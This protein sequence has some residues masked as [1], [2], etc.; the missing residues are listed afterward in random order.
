[1]S[2]TEKYTITISWPA[3]DT[4]TQRIT[5]NSKS[6]GNFDVLVYYTGCEYSFEIQT[7]SPNF[8]LLQK[9]KQCT[10]AQP[11][12]M[13]LAVANLEYRFFGLY[14]I[15]AGIPKDTVV[16]K[17]N[18]YKI[19]FQLA[20]PKCTSALD[21]DYPNALMKRCLKDYASHDVFFH[22]ESDLATT[23]GAHKWVLSQ[24]PYFKAM[25]ESGFKEGGSGNKTIPIKDV[26]PS[27]FKHLLRFIYVGTLEPTTVDLHDG[28]TS[29][30]SWEGIYVAADRY[31]IDDLRILALA[32]IEARMKSVAEVDFL[33]RSA[34]MYKELRCA[35][36]KYLAKKH[37]T[38]ISLEQ[39][40]DQYK[41][42][43]EIAELVGE[44][45]SETVKALRK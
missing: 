34:Y 43:R 3:S 26:K 45:Y 11:N 22:F 20:G 10:I 28:D 2:T 35:V 12:R 9:Y 31:M 30:A 41:D 18:L 40:L 13:P 23:V 17:D 6:C 37:Y 38:E 21:I 24:W 44:L 7:E 27:N 39:V 16:V 14:K 36:I 19:Q 29:M 8:T 32:K 4:G 25:F 5:V 1:M 15:V 33:F 42:H